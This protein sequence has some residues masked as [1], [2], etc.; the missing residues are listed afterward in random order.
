[1]A[2][3]NAKLAISSVYP[4]T[5]DYNTNML[6]A[7]S[8]RDKQVIYTNKAMCRDCYRCVRVCPVKAI[9]MESGQ[10]QV[11]AQR[12][13]ACG[14]CVR[15]CPQKAKMFRN[16]LE[17]AIQLVKSGKPVAVS[18][19]PSFAGLY[20]SWQRTRIPSV[21]R[22][23]G[24]S[25]IAE[26][27]VGA[28]F[29]AKATAEYI[30]KHP[31][32]PCICTSCPASNELIQRYHPEWIRYMV[33]VVSPMVAHAKHIRQKLGDDIHVVF[34]GPCTAKKA[35]A[36]LYQDDGR[37][38]CALTFDEFHEWLKRENLE[39]SSCEESDFD[40]QPRGA[41]RLFPLEGGCVRTAGWTSEHLDAKILAVSGFDIIEKALR[42]V[43]PGQVI[44][45]LFCKLGCAGGPANGVGEN[46]GAFDSR[47]DIIVYN[48]ECDNKKK[49]P[50]DDKLTDDELTDEDRRFLATLFVKFQPH[51]IAGRNVTEEQI[52]EVLEKTGK[53]NAE[54][55]L[56]CGACGYS[57][58]RAM[59]VA[60][61]EGI[62]EPEM[63][64]PYIKRL[65][66]Q[67][68][69][70]IIETSPSGILIL[71][72]NLDILSMNPAF[73]TFFQCSNAVVGRP[74]SYLMDPEPFERLMHDD[75]AS[76]TTAVVEETREHP[77]YHLVCHELFYALK[78]Q[79]QYVG[80]FVNI[81]KMQWS[82]SKLDKLREQ[83]VVQARELLEQQI[84]MAQTIAMT[85]GQNTA[86]AES[87]L[88]NLMEQ[89]RHD[90]T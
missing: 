26:T 48:E 89:A 82:Q 15:E 19:A 29:V 50:K 37:I 27:A 41:A 79:K 53:S 20:P 51:P 63:C 62:A 33:P 4:V 47:F 31:H 35:E 74:V 44:E 84:N 59:A 90:G 77:S 55:H 13:V 46:G 64:L 58:C 22:R 21:L 88:E 10:A 68:V 73:R 83:T 38:D 57:G 9:R 65:A 7:Q 17:L 69:D 12:C 85:L 34:L 16:D 43:R 6:P 61:I 72:E 71:D 42:E 25:H 60:V 81:T 78:E 30:Y 14:T 54:S 49:T 39:I 5:R 24:F 86:R 23:L 18:I 66:E 36:A 45:P 75:T 8:S 67:R 32:E 11:I 40:D 28:F 80:I 52:R 2:K 76:D 70:L 56:N 87:L 3:N 1:M